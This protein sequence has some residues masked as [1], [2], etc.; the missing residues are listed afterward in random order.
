MPSDPIAIFGMGMILKGVAPD[1]VNDLCSKLRQPLP[2]TE[3]S[4]D[5]EAD[6]KAASLGMKAWEARSGSWRLVVADFPIDDQRGRRPGDRGQTV[7]ISNL[8]IG[9]CIGGDEISLQLLAK[10]LYEQITKDF[11]GSGSMPTKNQIKKMLAQHK[12]KAGE[13]DLRDPEQLR[14]A[15]KWQ[16]GLIANFASDVGEWGIPRNGSKFRICRSKRHVE[17]IAGTMAMPVRI[18]FF[19]MGYTVAEQGV[20][21]HDIEMC[22]L[23]ASLYEP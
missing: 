18:A 9:L 4:M 10:W 12:F 14:V 1:A 5:S 23:W 15:V 3:V 11:V 16:E 13:L 6:K 20:S 21:D 2:W 22:H 8:E 17:V 7:A 19:A